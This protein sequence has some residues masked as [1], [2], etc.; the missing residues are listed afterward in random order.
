MSYIDDHFSGVSSPWGKD[1]GRMS[2]AD[3]KAYA[4][5]GT[6]SYTFYDE[7]GNEIGS[8][9]IDNSVDPN[10]IKKV[11]K[12]DDGT[13]STTAKKP[14]TSVII[15]GKGKITVKAPSYVLEREGFKDSIDKTLKTLS[16]Y[17]QQDPNYAIPLSDGSKKTVREII[18]ELN[19]PNNDE[20]IVKYAEDVANMRAQEYGTQDG[21]KG[22]RTVYKIGDNITLNDNYFR[23]RNAVALGSDV[24]DDTRQAISNLPEFDFLRKL[25]SYD[26]NTGTAQLKD[27]MENGWNRDKHSD[28][29]LKNAKDALERYFAQ[30]DYTDTDE[31]ARNIATYEFVTGRHP[32]VNWLR[33]VVETSGSFVEG[34][35]DFITDVGGYIYL[36]TTSAIFGK[37]DDFTEWAF[38]GLTG[39]EYTSA[40]I[41]TPY[42]AMTPGEYS[43][44]VLNY[45]E[46]TKDERQEDRHDH[47]ERPEGRR[48]VSDE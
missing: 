46:E 16:R 27:I 18:D 15:S 39:K 20:S 48:E 43:D 19:D 30:G 28:E 47:G 31:L 40:K 41:W 36:G 44:T 4:S 45:W 10:T 2:E 37:V 26:S 13:Y 9:N 3:K 5:T 8:G 1:T 24:K 38:E 32:D 25:D 34:V 42:G 12:Q 17:Y 23:I 11:Y 22:D 29:E 35:W 33:N 21:Y 14:E 6:S 7:D